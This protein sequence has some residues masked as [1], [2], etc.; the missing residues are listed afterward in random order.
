MKQTSY[1]ALIIGASAGGLKAMSVI[2]PQLPQVFPLVVIVVN[3]RMETPDTYLTEYL[4]GICHLPVQD[5]E[6]LFPIEP[7]HIY[8]APPGYHLLVADDYCFNLSEDPRVNSSRPSIDV[9]FE[10]AADVYGEYLI[11]VVLTGA[12]SDGAIGLAEIKANGG[13]TIVQDPSEAEA[14]AMPSAAIKAGKP[15]FVGSL[16]QIARQICVISGVEKV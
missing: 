10:S 8:V 13:Y 15:D 2:L 1:Q 5:A 11:G 3:H 6:H 16:D 14:I 9:A 7:G 12:N 4:N